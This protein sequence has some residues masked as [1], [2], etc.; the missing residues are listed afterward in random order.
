MTA[1]DVLGFAGFLAVP[2]L[3][4]LIGLAFYTVTALHRRIADRTDSEA[5]SHRHR[6]RIAPTRDRVSL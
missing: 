3:V 1:V 5:R 4:F 2:P 6:S